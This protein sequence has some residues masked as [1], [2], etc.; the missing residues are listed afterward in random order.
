MVAAKIM[1]V[2]CRSRRSG[3]EEISWMVPVGEQT[4]QPFPKAEFGVT[5]IGDDDIGDSGGTSLGFRQKAELDYS[6]SEGQAALRSM[7]RVGKG[8][9]GNLERKAFRAPEPS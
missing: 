9:I 8:D 5:S 2:P 1:T 7:L 3:E 6:N 4:S